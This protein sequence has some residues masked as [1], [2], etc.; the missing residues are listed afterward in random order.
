MPY[1]LIWSQRFQLAINY[2]FLTNTLKRDFSETRQKMTV[3]P[4]QRLSTTTPV[5]CYS[6]S[7]THLITIFQHC[8]LKLKTNCCSMGDNDQYQK[9]ALICSLSLFPSWS[10]PTLSLTPYYSCSVSCIEMLIG[11]QSSRHSTN[12]TQFS[13]CLQPFMLSSAV[14]KAV[15]VIQCVLQHHSPPSGSARYFSVCCVTTVSHKA[16]LATSVCAASP[17]SHIR[18]CSLLQCVLHHHGPP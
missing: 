4:S 12:C 3:F 11:L 10:H 18:Q 2:I 14:S 17:Q 7:F 13:V 1:F 16:M 8:A 6:I 9:K 5:Y 15:L